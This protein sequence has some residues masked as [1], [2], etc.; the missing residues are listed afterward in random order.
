MDPFS[1]LSSNSYGIQLEPYWENVFPAY[2]EWVYSESYREAIWRSVTDGLQD[3]AEEVYYIGKTWL[4]G[5]YV[6]DSESQSKTITYLSD[7]T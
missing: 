5:D 2:L 6:D 1:D 7:S 3:D 4:L